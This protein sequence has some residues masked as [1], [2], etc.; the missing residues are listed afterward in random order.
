MSTATSG[1]LAIVAI[2]VALRFVVP[3]LI[4]RWPLPAIIVCLVVDGVDQTVFQTYLS[5]DFWMSIEH[6][7]Q[8]YDKALDVFYLSMAYLATM[9]N[10]TNPTALL[11]AQFLW[12]Y[13][14]VGVAT[15]EILHDAADPSSWR[16]LL[17]IFPNTFEYF[18][19]A[20]EAVRLRWDPARM[21]PRLVV[22]IAAFIWIFV[23]LPQEWWIH[24]AQLDM[25]DE[26]AAHPWIVWV[27]VVG[28]L[29]VVALAWWAITYRLPPADW[30]LQITAPPM[31]GSLASARQRS[32]WRAADWRLWD[33]NL[34]EKVVL[35][36]LTCIIFAEILP[37]VTERPLTMA[38]WVT[39][40]IVVNTAL[41]LAFVR[42]GHT[43]DRYIWQFLAQLAVNEG[44][45]IVASLFSSR[46]RVSHALFFLLLITLITTLYDRYRPVREYHRR[47]AAGDLAPDPAPTRA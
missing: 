14:L 24:V 28:I 34:V 41:G 32:S 17:L 37:G 40:L 38:L 16:W 13:R 31:P 15:F 30:R 21:S 8:G 19:I 7:Y 33:W 36:A 35:V 6:A 9:R 45:V 23:K 46:F 3:L 26:M 10:W 25:T 39:G 29:A 43:I 20:Y 12:I 18:F 5:H 42:R 1:D 44:V 22:G 11:T 27:M 2:V 47:E 4:P